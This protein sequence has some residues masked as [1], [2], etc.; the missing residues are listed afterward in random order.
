LIHIKFSP[1]VPWKRTVI[2]RPIFYLLFFAAGLVAGGYLFSR[3]LPR[4]FLALGTCD[5]HCYKADEVAGLLAS[6][7]IQRVPGL[8]PD[9][10]LESDTC[11]AVRHPRPQ[12]RI[13]FVLFPK[14]DVKNIATLTPDDV[15]YVLGCF[16]MIRELVA[17]DHL[18]DY[19]V[20]TNG[21]ARQ[22][23]TYLHFHLIAN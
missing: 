8:I 4:S 21:P 11:L 14:R 18:D 17:R 10:V 23:V 1:R 6:A 22:D 16:A 20:L 12:E 15:P 13:H 3:S 7:A 9:V 5:Q 19:R 2:R